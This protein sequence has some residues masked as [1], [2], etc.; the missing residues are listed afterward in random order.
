MQLGNPMLSE[1]NY[2]KLVSPCSNGVPLG[3]MQAGYGP[4]PMYGFIRN[5][6][7][8]KMFA[9]VWDHLETDRLRLTAISLISLHLLCTCASLL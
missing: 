5:A 1:K 2:V 9:N 3:S 7:K 4:D 6:V 8:T